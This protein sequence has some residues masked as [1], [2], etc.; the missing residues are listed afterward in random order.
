MAAA[1]GALKPCLATIGTLRAR[2]R[3]QFH[4]WS[5]CA[6]SAKLQV[7]TAASD[8]QRSTERPPDGNKVELSKPLTATK[9]VPQKRRPVRDVRGVSVIYQQSA[10]EIHRRKKGDSAANP[11]KSAFPAFISA[12]SGGSV[13]VSEPILYNRFEYFI[14]IKTYNGF[15]CD[16]LP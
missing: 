12:T 16:R 1:T 3:R 14:G 9:N 2:N 11:V 10:T 7:H 6:L 8:E 4:A 15:H 5:K 13:V